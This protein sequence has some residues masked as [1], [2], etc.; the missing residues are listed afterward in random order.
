MTIRTDN[1]E[2][3]L[4]ERRL[5]SIRG[6]D[7]PRRDRDSPSSVAANDV[8]PKLTRAQRSILI[9][10]VAQYYFVD[11]VR[12]ALVDEYPDF[13]V[14][15]DELI[16]YYRRRIDADGLAEAH[17]ARDLALRTGLANKAVRVKCL[18]D[19]AVQLRRVPLVE[20]QVGVGPDG[21]AR[22][23]YTTRQDVS[24]ELREVLKQIAQEL[25]QYAPDIP[26]PALSRPDTPFDEDPAE[27]EQLRSE[28]QE[29]LQGMVER[30]I[31]ERDALAASQRPGSVIG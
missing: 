18:M 29:L 25:G 24:R 15:S 20:T 22:T 13:P 14:I 1:Q 6:A 10:L 2:K 8:G 31:A 19:Q 4:R 21:Q 30:D 12:A 16:R 11:A 26:L 5:R 27:A 3:N 28:L 23:A 17:A 9:T 7:E